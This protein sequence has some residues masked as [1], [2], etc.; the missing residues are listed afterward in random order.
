M[1]T[2]T[3]T[4]EAGTAINDGGKIKELYD[5]CFNGMMTGGEKSVHDFNWKDKL[6]KFYVSWDLGNNNVMNGIQYFVPHGNGLTDLL[7]QTQKAD[8]MIWSSVSKSNDGLSSSD[9]YKS[10]YAA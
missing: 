1:S 4:L 2:T 9:Y 7:Q 6:Y 10:A 3:F 5:I 8:G